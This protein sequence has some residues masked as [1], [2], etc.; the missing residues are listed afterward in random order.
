MSLSY[1]N[2]FSRILE[3]IK[4]NRTRTYK[5]LSLKLLSFCECSQIFCFAEDADDLRGEGVRNVKQSGNVIK[6]V[7]HWFEN[8]FIYSSLV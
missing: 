3:K 8:R 1:P 2:N 7:R 5:N 4:L 6:Q